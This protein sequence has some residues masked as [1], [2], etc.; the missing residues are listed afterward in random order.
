MMYRKPHRTQYDGKAKGNKKVDFGDFGLM[1]VGGK[2]L[3][4]QRVKRTG[5]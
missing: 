5:N 3:T 4:C 2:G 1:C